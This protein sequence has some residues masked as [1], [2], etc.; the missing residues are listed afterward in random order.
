LKPFLFV[1]IC[2]QIIYQ[3]P[4][5]GLHSGAGTGGW[6][7]VIGLFFIWK[8]DSVTGIASS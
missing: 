2:L 1:E 3:I 5:D 7:D 8:Y 6:Q 4:V